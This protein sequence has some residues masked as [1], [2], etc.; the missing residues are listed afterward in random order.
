MKLPESN[1]ARRE[2]ECPGVTVTKAQS[3]DQVY[4]FDREEI[5]L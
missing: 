1:L 3:S 2:G 5:T 4:H